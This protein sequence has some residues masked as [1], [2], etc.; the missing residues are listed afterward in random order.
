MNEENHS[1][2]RLGM[3]A[4]QFIN[5][6]LGKYLIERADND[7][8]ESKDALLM[9]NP[10]D[11]NKIMEYQILGRA[12]INFKQWLIECIENGEMAKGEIKE[13]E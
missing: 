1:I 13:Y 6:E 7:I 9:A 4:E 5:T 12:A 10:L 3:Y 8:L 11:A 2:A